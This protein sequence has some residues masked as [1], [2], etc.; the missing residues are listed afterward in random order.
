M[1]ILC[2]VCAELFCPLYV[3]PAA[4]AGAKLKILTKRFKSTSL[5]TD[6]D[7]PY[8]GQLK[9]IISELTRRHPLLPNIMDTAGFVESFSQ[10]SAD[11][12]DIKMILRNTW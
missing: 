10:L 3:T 2:A 6:I 9:S 4:P 12:Q 11:D 5:P 8:I 1:T 7:K